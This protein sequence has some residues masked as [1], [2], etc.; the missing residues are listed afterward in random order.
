MLRFVEPSDLPQLGRLFEAWDI[1][2]EPGR[3]GDLLD[4]LTLVAEKAGRPVGC[5]SA[6]VGP[7]RLAYLD[8]LVVEPTDGGARLS[9]TLLAAIEDLLARLGWRYVQACIRF[10]RPELLS[11]A[12]RLHYIDYGLHNLVG[13]TLTSGSRENG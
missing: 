8:N 10:D 4:Q 13:K 6:L 1:G 3:E 7:S 11:Y 12:E 2:I 9:Y 5:V